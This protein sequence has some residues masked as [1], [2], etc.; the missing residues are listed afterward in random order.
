[1]PTGIFS[2]ATAEPAADDPEPVAIFVEL[3]SDILRMRSLR[4]VDSTL[5]KVITVGREIILILPS[6][7]AAVR[8]AFILA[9]RNPNLNP[10]AGI[11]N[12]GETVF[13]LPLKGFP[14][15]NLELERN[16]PLT[17]SISAPRDLEKEGV[18]SIRF[19]SIRT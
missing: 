9:A 4:M 2:V 8:K 16:R 19:D 11:G 10:L 3:G 18:V 12:G 5:F 7:S 1:M 17:R 13:G 6:F 15:R 14:A